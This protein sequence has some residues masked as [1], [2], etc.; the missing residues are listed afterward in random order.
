[1]D[2]QFKKLLQMIGIVALGMSAA[3]AEITPS[4]SPAEVA[5]DLFRALKAGQ[6]ESVKSMLSENV[7]VFEG[8]KLEDSFT[9]YAAHHL[10][11]DMAFLKDMQRAVLE[12]EEV[13][14]TEVATV[15]SM[16]QLSGTY[17]NREMRVKMTETLV[18]ERA[19]TGWLIHV[20]HWSAQ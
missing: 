20:I 10:E 12:R 15:T 6:S 18:M 14:S 2:M 19:E 11:A 7:K 1:M 8:G 5:D 4:G 9:A 3:M 16:Y 17:Q 13:L